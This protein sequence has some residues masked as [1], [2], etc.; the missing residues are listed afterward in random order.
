M[1]RPTKDPSGKT[2]KDLAKIDRESKAVAAQ[3][4]TAMLMGHGYAPFLRKPVNLLDPGDVERRIKAYWASCAKSGAIP[5]PPGLRAY[6]RVSIGQFREWLAGI[7]T[8]ENRDLA[9]KTYNLLEQ[10]IIDFHLAGK[11]SPQSMQFLTQN[12]FGYQ[13][14]NA[15]ELQQA[16]PAPPSLDKLAAEAAALP[17]GDVVDV[18]FVE[19]ESGGKKQK[20]KKKK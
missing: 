4:E 13:S 9:V 19:I 11:I 5:S 6:L 2:V 18:D 17:D 7:G 10:A 8:I 20:E 3:E 15:L 1:A 14:K 16:A 12:W